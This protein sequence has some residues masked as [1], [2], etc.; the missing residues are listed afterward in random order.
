MLVGNDVAFSPIAGAWT[1][2]TP[3]R[4]GITIGNGT[5]SARYLQVGKTVAINYKLTLGTTSSVSGDIAISLP[6]ANNVLTVG[7]ASLF[8]TGT[9]W[10]GII[11]LVSSIMYVRVLETSGTYGNYKNCSATIPAT[12]SSAAAIYASVVYE[13]A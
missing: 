1:S 5:E 2:W 6:V 9:D 10:Q 11:F 13:A 4:T 12:W 3:S 8:V 7:S